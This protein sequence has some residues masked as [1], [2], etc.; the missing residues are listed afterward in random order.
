MHLP[1]LQMNRDRFIGLSLFL[2]LFLV[3]ILSPV[4]HI[5][6]S[7][8][9]LLVS[10]SIIEHHT[11]QLGNYKIPSVSRQNSTKSVRLPYQIQIIDKK[12]YY[13]FPYG[14]AVL[15]VPYVALA[16]TIFHISPASP[17]GR[18]QP[19]GERH[20]QVFLAALLMSL[21]GVIF[22][23]T[24]RL[25]MEKAM[26][27]VIVTAA[28]GTQIWSTASRQVESH[29]WMIFLLA[30]AIY[31]IFGSKLGRFK[32]NGFFL[33][34]IL[35]WMYFVRPTAAIDVLL[36]TAYVAFQFRKALLPHIITGL[37]WCALF[38]FFSYSVFGKPFPNYYQAGRLFT[39]P[40][41]EFLLGHLISPSRGLFVFLPWTIFLT[42]LI[43]K[44]FRL[45]VH[46][47]LLILSLVAI[48]FHILIVSAYYLW[49]GG[50]SFGPRLLS[51]IVPWLILSLILTVKAWLKQQTKALS[52]FRIEAYA[53][54]LL[55]TLSILINGY[56]AISINAW[57]WNVIPD[58]IDQNPSRLWDWKNP[59]F[60]P[61]HNEQKLEDEESDS[62]SYLRPLRISSSASSAIRFLSSSSIC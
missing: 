44:T 43:G 61:R 12:P 40:I 46:K 10:L 7:R 3:F 35:S 24:A 28:L 50:H 9:S 48:V 32:I 30:I 20:L 27:L 19:N 62:G 4:R 38:L 6:D 37:I 26:S 60:W 14:G 49:W 31:H 39:Y 41:P 54:I 13:I 53:G 21:T 57:K 29:T 51:N 17:D 16:K 1:C 42:Y 52:V 47:D 25:I 11:F 23:F 15:S 59:Q 34:T 45:I 56:G 55:I 22:Y 33:G 18:Y 2:A 5:A 8:F 36:I 58:N